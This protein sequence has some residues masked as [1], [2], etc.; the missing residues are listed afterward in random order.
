MPENTQMT[1]NREYKIEVYVPES[2]LD[3]VRDALHDAGAGRIGS[4][5]R[6]LSVTTV[7]GFWRPLDGSN[8]FIGE[9][10]EIAEG[11]EYKIE[12]RCD[13]AHVAQAV[14]AV[15]AVHPYEEPVINVIPLANQDFDQLRRTAETHS[16][17][18]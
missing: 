14:S 2:H 17:V 1:E 9:A 15:R 12:V 5:D 8:P 4:Y 13:K 7:R 10:G 6:C 11:M 18:A 3:A 16:P